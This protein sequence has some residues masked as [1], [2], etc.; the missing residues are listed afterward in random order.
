MSEEK[1]DNLCIMGKG[2]E[3]VTHEQLNLL[4]RRALAFHARPQRKALERVACVL[5]KL[6][7]RLDDHVDSSNI[8]RAELKGIMRATKTFIAIAAGVATGIISA[9]VA[10]FNKPD[11]LRIF[12][13]D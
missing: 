5:E 13:L 11:L 4:M 9:I 3:P 1:S 8:N 12:F 7:Q 10:L 6:E 2:D